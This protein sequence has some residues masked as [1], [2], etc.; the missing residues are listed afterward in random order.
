[1]PESTIDG[2]LEHRLQ[3]VGT[4]DLS[5]EDEASICLCQMNLARPT[6]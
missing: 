1:M 4:P 6:E 2:N 3:P 5:G